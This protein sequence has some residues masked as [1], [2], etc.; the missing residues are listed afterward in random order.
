M[1]TKAVTIT[2]AVIG[3]VATL[4]AALFSN[5][6]KPKESSASI[7][8]TA[9]GAGAVNV[10][11]NAVFNTNNIKS[12][13]EEAAER[14]QA[15]EAQHGMKTASDKT[16]SLQTIPASDAGPQSST[17]HISFRACVWPRSRYADAD[18][19]LEIKVQSVQGPGD[20]EASGTNA[21]DR[22]AAP[23]QQLTVAYQFGSQGAYENTAPITI[24]ADTV[25]TVDGKPWKQADNPLDFYPDSGE[26]VVLHDDHYMIEN[27]SCP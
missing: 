23:C 9:S 16:D 15:C 26:F 14:V 1:T 17:E 10:G 27:A 11:G 5:L 22:I 4:G 3:A 18:G 7:Q 21:A 6:N 19:Y 8:Q 24:T 13:A 25:V 12:P 20:N 2:V